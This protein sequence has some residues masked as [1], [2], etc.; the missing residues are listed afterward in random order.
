VVARQG[1]EAETAEEEGE[2]RITSRAVT[3]VAVI[4][5]THL[6][7]GARQLPEACLERV[8][9]ADLILHAGDVSTVAALDTLRALGPP[10]EAVHGNA[11]EPA[12]QA[13]LPGER[14]V[15][16]AGARI[17]MRH[18]P[19]PA[20]GREERLARRFQG[21]D[22]VVFGHTHLPV[23]ERYG[24]LWLLN[25]GSPTERR[26]GPHRAMLVLEIAA[27]EVRPELVELT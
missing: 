7:R 6:P 1:R 20:A 8:R 25:P 16:V 12:L 22:A 23:V 4:S 19:G 17:G 11:D 18:D 15:E 3:V 9:T 5:D 26:R 13:T 21:C 2:A 14:V 27:G 10:L 24:H